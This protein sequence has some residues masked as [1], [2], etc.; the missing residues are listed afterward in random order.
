[1]RNIKLAAN[2]PMK[3]PEIVDI[4]D[5]L[6]KAASWEGIGP[7]KWTVKGS[8]DGH[9]YLTGLRKPEDITTI[10]VHHS[11]P[12]NG[13]LESHARYHASKWG[14]GIAYH[15]CIDQGRIYQVNDLLSMTYHAGNNNTYT[16]GIEV[17][18]D[19]TGNDLTETERTLLYA[20]ILTV[21]GLFPTITD[22]KGHNEL[23]T[24]N[25]AC[26]VTSMA[27]IREDIAMLEE[28]MDYNGTPNADRAL[29]YSFAERVDDLGKRRSD[30]KW[31]AAAEAKIMWLSPAMT[32]LGVTDELTTDYIVKYWKRVYDNS[33]N[34]KFQ[35][36]AF[37][38]LLVGAN[39]AKEKGLL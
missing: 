8:W 12:P 4:T 17:N 39:L 35:G 15:I 2:I 29:C 3:V 25:T 10:V 27:R 14:A 22:I 19:I 26:P 37:R 21:K 31:G 18:R 9:T 6:P 7:K 13:T 32:D 28:Q 30:P 5:S 23:P 36:E 34:E 24:C 1:M 20:A 16:I 33:Y 38:K 11:G